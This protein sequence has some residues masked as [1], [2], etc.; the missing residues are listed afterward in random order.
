MCDHSD[1]TAVDVPM[2]VPVATAVSRPR[3]KFSTCACAVN[4]D[5]MHARCVYFGT[6]RSDAFGHSQKN[7][8]LYIITILFKSVTSSSTEI[9]NDWMDCLESRGDESV[10]VRNPYALRSST[11]VQL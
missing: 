5:S 8:L 7:V 1:F 3:T 11:A 10:R 2:D 9:W 6:F 4:E